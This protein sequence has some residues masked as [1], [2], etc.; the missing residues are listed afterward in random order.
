MLS[1]SA[2]SG[3]LDTFTQTPAFSRDVLIQPSRAVR[4]GYGGI[5]LL[6]VLIAVAGVANIYTVLNQ[7]NT[8]APASATLSLGVGLVLLLIAF[9]LMWRFASPFVFAIALTHEGLAWRTM[10]GWRNARWRDVAFLLVQPHTAF[11]GHE[12]YIR[13]D[14]STFH[15]GW[16]EPGDKYFFGPLEALPAE[17]AK[18]L[19]HTV[20]ERAQ[21]QRREPGIW[22]R[23]GD[24]KID[25]KTGQ[26][27]W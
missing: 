10:L 14:K 11:G 20:V 23:H 21:L 1:D 3:K 5:L 9:G 13:A 24:A 12:V 16:V 19:L 15:F 22:V 27:R 4:T 7:A 18:S 2:F 17:E 8:P 26:M 25:V 6:A